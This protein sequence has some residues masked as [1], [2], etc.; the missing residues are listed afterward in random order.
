VEIVP[1]RNKTAESVVE[2]LL[3]IFMRHGAPRHLLSDRG[4][5]F[6]NKML[7]RVCKLL[8][9]HQIHI[10]PVNPR[11]NGLAENHMRTLK[12]M[13]SA[14]VDNTQSNWAE[15]LPAVA[16]IYNTTVNFSTNYTPFYLNHG[17]PCAS[18]DTEYLA[19]E[20]KKSELD[21]Y[22]I[23]LRDALA[24]AWHTISGSAWSDKTERYNARPSA[25]LAF[26]HYEVNQLVFMK[27]I[28]RRFYK[29]QKD[30]E[31]HAL[32]AKLQPRYSGPY[33]ITKVLS[34]VLYQA[35]VHGKTRT[36]HAINIKPAHVF[37][38]VAD[39][40]HN[41]EQAEIEMDRDAEEELQRNATPVANHVITQQLASMLSP[42]QK[43]ARDIAAAAESLVFLQDAED[44]ATVAYV[45]I[46]SI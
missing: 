23:G 1:L 13:L 39:V 26:K 35:Q 15:H 34:D 25:P 37:L 38:N 30:E 5:E 33:R 45:K 21:E 7:G 10:T 17:R 8:D 46:T 6:T 43:A 41:P 36:L 2:A 9:T 40:P 31:L 16:H 44:A 24:L 27:R 18:P 22:T 14:H 20:I 4:R 28:P 3:V 32:S 42:A 29:S 12:D 19:T 11:A